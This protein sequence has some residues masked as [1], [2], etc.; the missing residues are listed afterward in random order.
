MDTLRSLQ[1]LLMIEHGKLQISTEASGGPGIQ[2]PVSGPLRMLRV[3]NF[4][5]LLLDRAR[6]A[7]ESR[8]CK[9]MRPA[10]PSWRNPSIR[11][12]AII[13][14]GKTLFLSTHSTDPTNNAVGLFYRMP[15]DRD[16]GRR[17]IQMRRVAEL[18]ANAGW[19]PATIIPTSVRQH[20]A[21]DPLH[22]E[23]L[24][25]RAG[26][27]SFRRMG[28]HMKLAEL[29]PEPVRNKLNLVSALAVAYNQQS[30]CADFGK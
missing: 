13:P 15:G 24:S 16:Q 29:W 9:L 8:D 26:G 17:Q 20:P 2:G 7:L 21:P 22:P 19:R 14:E 11:G 23:R 30:G 3:R 1:I 5:G 25:A 10:F 28:I 12:V 27:P 6:C 18:V 4:A